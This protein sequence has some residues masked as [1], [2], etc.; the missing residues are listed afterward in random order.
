MAWTPELPSG[1][2][3]GYHQHACVALPGPPLLSL[4]TLH[5]SLQVYPL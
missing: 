2:D 1:K 3:V 4:H 5:Q